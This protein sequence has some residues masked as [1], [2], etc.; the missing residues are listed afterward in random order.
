MPGPG[1]PFV[2]GVSGNPS[3]RRRHGPPPFDLVK[4]CR[5]LTPQLVE[6]LVLLTTE[7][8]RRVAVQAIT[9]LLDR[10]WGRA[11]Q[12]VEVD[13]DERMVPVSQI[14]AAARYVREK[15]DLYA[16]DG[17]GE[18]SG[19]T[20]PENGRMDGGDPGR[21]LVPDA[22][23]PSSSSSIGELDANSPKSRLLRELLGNGDPNA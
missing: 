7:P 15:L 1:R 5:E 22:T 17:Q 18:P 8:D 4:Q 2:Q 10:G 23:D 21:P 12:A 20:V 6:R 14:E 13:L 11:R 9:Y 3:G 19:S 16:G